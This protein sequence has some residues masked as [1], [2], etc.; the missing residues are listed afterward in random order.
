M[1]RKLDRRRLPSTT[2]NIGVRRGRHLPG[3]I[4]GIVCGAYMRRKRFRNAIDYPPVFP[5]SH[6]VRS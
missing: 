1:D 2:K 5:F 4:S 3:H 6:P